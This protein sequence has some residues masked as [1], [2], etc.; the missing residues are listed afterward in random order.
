MTGAA[1]R[2]VVDVAVK[3]FEEGIL[4]AEVKTGADGTY[5]LRF[6]Y[7]PDIDWTIVVWFVPPTPDLVPEIVILRESLRA[8]SL[9][10]WSTCLPRT[11]L[12]GQMHFDV[13]LV[14]DATKRQMISQLECFKRQAQ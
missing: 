10:L 14:D 7:L 13:Q 11:D 3:I 1:G 8:K 4:L 5:L 12:R 2:P 9:D 6:P